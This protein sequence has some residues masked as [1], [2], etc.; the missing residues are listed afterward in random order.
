MLRTHYNR[1]DAVRVA[2]PPA[3]PVLPYGSPA[4]HYRFCTNRTALENADS[5]P[6]STSLD[7]IE[8]PAH[9]SRPNVIPPSQPSTTVNSHFRHSGWTRQR[10][11][12]YEAMKQLH[13]SPRRLQRF[14][15]CGSHAWVEGSTE[16][17][18]TV[19][20]AMQPNKNPNCQTVP[21]GKAKY[22]VRC[23]TCRDRFCQPCASTRSRI[24]AHAIIDLLGD[25]PARFITLTVRSN[26]EPLKQ[27]I[28]RL[29]VSFRK[30]RRTTLWIRHCYAAAATLEITR[31][32]DTGQWHPHLHVLAKGKYIPH[33]ELKA[34]W[35]R[36]TKDSHV[37]DIRLVKHREKA[38]RY[39]S[40][41][42][43][44][45]MTHQYDTE[46]DALTEAIA[47][48]KGRRLILLTGE[49]QSLHVEH[50]SPD[51]TWNY[52]GTLETLINRGIDGDADAVAI[53]TFLRSDSSCWK[54]KPGQ[55]P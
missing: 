8:T 54:T 51:G 9:A 50:K 31:N 53:L 47:A 35:L 25:Q 46:P 3:D 36:I 30:L 52:V 44:K 37:V 48:L 29:Y 55:P 5:S 19:P 21:P 39:L 28:D 7:A 4:S 22:R 42:V 23:N 45:P 41:Y 2:I 14:A 16:S 20:L 32:R 18:Y 17:P 6:C 34:E 11:R 1:T 43:A 12:V 33:A 15:E 38:I 40:K 49:W 24:V 26:D 27:Q 10:S 13:L